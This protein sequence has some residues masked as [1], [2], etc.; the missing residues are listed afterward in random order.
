MYANLEKFAFG[1]NRV[2]YL[3]YIVDEHGMHVDPVKIQVI[4]D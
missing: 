1:M 3:G 4:H 2:K